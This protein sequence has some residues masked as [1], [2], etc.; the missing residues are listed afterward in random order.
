M[1]RIGISPTRN[2]KSSYIPAEVSVAVL[3][4]IPELF[5]Y[6]KHRLDVLKITLQS[7]LAN[8]E[9]PYDLMVFDNGSCSEVTEYLSRLKSEGMIDYLFLSHKNIG[10]FGALQIL[11]NSAPGKYIAYA[12]DDVFFY[13]GWLPAHLKIMSA[14]P[15]VGMVS[16][17][18]VR[19]EAER[20]SKSLEKYIQSEPDGLTWTN[21]RRLPDS[22][23]IE[24]ANSTGRDP[25]EHLEKTKDKL[26]LILKLNKIEV[27]AGANHFQF[28][29]PRDVLI[30]TLPSEWDG[31][32]MGEMKELDEAVDQQGL[33]RLSTVDRFVKHMGNVVSDELKLEAGKLGIDINS[34]QIDKKVKKHWLLRIPGMGR[35]FWKIYDWLFSV[36]HKV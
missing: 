33:L 19:N 23:E 4:F 22:W 9:K 11:F 7:I 31:R 1:T 36:L 8:T 25:A 32:L 26:D 3:S 28:L 5:G 16:G 17:V 13:P 29:A 20:S 30:N 34:T 2:K 10:N 18:G 21:E 15:N 27:F 14:Y 24:W 35:I 6:Y 12:D